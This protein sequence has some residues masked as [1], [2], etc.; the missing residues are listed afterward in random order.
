MKSSH[1]CIP[2]TAVDEAVGGAAAAIEVCV[3]ILSNKLSVKTGDWRA[4]S[5]RQR[6]A[7]CELRSTQ[8]LVVINLVQ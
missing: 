1:W 4:Q 8:T 2:A 5:Q 3:G 7:I 6:L